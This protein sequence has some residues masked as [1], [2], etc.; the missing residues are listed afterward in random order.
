MRWLIALLMAWSVPAMS[1]ETVIRDKI[2]GI[3]PVIQIQSVKP[4]ADSPFFEVVLSNGERIYTDARAQHFVAGDLYAVGVGQV[5]NLTIWRGRMNGK[6]CSNRWM[7]QNS[8]YLSPK[9]TSRM[10]YWF[11]RTST[12]AIAGN[13][14]R[15]L[16]IC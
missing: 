6:S 2:L 13:C 9:G 8:L 14:T 1:D 3:N 5:T 10:T 11:S 15:K 7:L 12:V 16:R 4:I